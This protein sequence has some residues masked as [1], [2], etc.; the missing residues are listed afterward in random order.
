MRIPYLTPLR[1]LR[2]SVYSTHCLRNM[3]AKFCLTSSTHNTNVCI[4]LLSLILR[5]SLYA[6]RELYLE[7][8]AALNTYELYNQD[9]NTLSRI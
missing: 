2:V 6:L 9:S 5:N 1:F 3:Q 7:A 4:F 8:C